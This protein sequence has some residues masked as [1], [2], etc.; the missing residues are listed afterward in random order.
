M[1]LKRWQ[2]I[3]VGIFALLLISKHLL[4]DTAAAPSEKFVIDVDA[5]HRAAIA[6]G[7]P[8]AERIEVEK[9]A[10]FAFP[11]TLVVAGDGWKMH[12]MVLLAHRVVWPGRSLLIDTAMSPAATKA[13]PGSKADAAAF[14]RVEAAMKQA[15]TIVFTHEHSDHVGGVAAAQD[16]A[17]IA[18]KVFMTREQL[19]GPKLERGEFAAGALE[20][21]KP[22]D[23]QGLHTIAPGVVLQKAPGHSVGTQLV[24]VELASGTRYLFV[25]DIAW[26][27]DNITRQIGRPGIATLL[28]K[29]DRPAVAAQVQA[30][31][32]LPKD[33]HLIVAHDPLAYEKDLK[34]GLFKPGF[35]PP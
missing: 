5:L 29:E 30:L 4:L 32:A 35:S 8:L 16:F 23:Y 21:L 28:M 14:L 18:G 34:A 10:E 22:L 9:V 6:T 20:S 25:G 2:W 3:C 7:Q 19:N 31:A 11:R 17:A 33:I 1:R 13:L 15:D 26:S 27:Y 24:Y 12:P